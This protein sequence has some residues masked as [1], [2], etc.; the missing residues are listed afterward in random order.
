V[1]RGSAGWLVAVV[2]LGVGCSSPADY[3]RPD[4][5]LPPPTTVAAPNA[6][7]SDIP[8][9]V[10][11]IAVASEDDLVAL[12]AQAPPGSTFVIEPGVHRT[13]PLVPKDEMTFL[14]R[15]GAILSGAQVLEGFE[16]NGD[17]WELAGVSLDETAHGEC[18]AGYRA[19]ALRN[20]L[21]IDD[22]MLWR[23]D[24][25]DGLQ[26]GEW[27]GDGN[28]VVIADDPSRRV[29][30][31][32]VE[33]H[34]FVSDADD[35]TI[36]GLVVEKYAV[37]AQDGA[38]QSLS[39]SHQRLGTGWII[40]D[41]ETR[42]NH[43]AGIRTGDATVVRRVLSHHN[44]QLGI[45]GNAG[46][47]V[48][49]EDS[50]IAAN[51]TR[52]FFWEWEGGG[53]KFT[54]TSGLIV[55]DTY[56]HDNQ[57]PGLWTD[58]DTVDTTYASNRVTDN[59]GPGIFH[60]ISGSAA[61]HDNDVSGN[62]FGKPFWGWGAG[63]LVAASADVEVSGN[64]VFDNADGIVG[65]QQ[66]RGDGPSGPRLLTG[67]NVHD[68]EVGLSEGMMGVVQDNAARDLFTDRDL[69][70]DRNHYSGVG[71]RRAYAWDNEMRNRYGWVETGNDVAGTWD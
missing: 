19:C 43:A 30:E 57:G 47:D 70:F 25:P 61:I 6:A 53:A 52:G 54:Q 46:T 71:D 31:L 63:I 11:A 50:E 55:R 37:P 51:N 44:G 42:L 48:V 17:T 45:A 69:R 65:I 66:D 21:F 3:V 15:P 40:E 18:I 10:G 33:S 5:E 35:V 41:V 59:A 60:E 14:G 29:V 34:A 62:G 28:R 26:P 39:A 2:L 27:W 67:L 13:G 7:S 36:N 23:A 24:T 4:I 64:R 16:P 56:A 20:D 8:T 49:V 32:S 1:S 9:R 38:I 68:N 22:V 58:L 12:V